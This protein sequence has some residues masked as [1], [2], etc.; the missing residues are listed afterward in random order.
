MKTVS[1]SEVT[2]LSKS[3][4][5]YLSSFF[6]FMFGYCRDLTDSQILQAVSN[7]V[8]SLPTSP[9]PPQNKSHAIHQQPPRKLEPTRGSIADFFQP[10]SLSAM[11]FSK[12]NFDLNPAEDIQETPKMADS[13]GGE[14]GDELLG[15]LSGK[16]CES[17]RESKPL[18]KKKPSFVNRMKARPGSNLFQESEHETD[19][20][21]DQEE[22]SESES[23]EDDISKL[24]AAA[25]DPQNSIDDSVLGMLSGQ[26]GGPLL[27]G[28][29]DL[30][31]A[32]TNPSSLS[33][34][35]VQEEEED[36]NLALE[37]KDM[38]MEEADDEQQTQPMEGD[39]GLDEKKM[40]SLAMLQQN[41][42][43]QAKVKAAKQQKPN[44]V[45]VEN[46][47]QE[48]EDEFMGMGGVDGEDSDSDDLVC[49]GDE[50]VVED[51]EDVVELH[52]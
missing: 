13:Q 51:F 43:L 6:E 42:L 48:E 29:E 14:L 20:E 1:Q 17:N 52:R 5:I 15:L 23:D 49:S 46:E 39:G 50:D 25:D 30:R 11:K 18:Q 44:S 19:N 33:N 12:T 41:Q 4:L 34:E 35:L 24:S 36:Y 47:A 21:D 26:F 10:K 45:Y 37:T 32:P 8:S 22:G 3:N 40:L 31:S 16:F 9:H 7:P 38:N 2:L 28:L 27:S